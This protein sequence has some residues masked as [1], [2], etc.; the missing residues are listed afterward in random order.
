MQSCTDNIR[1]IYIPQYE[2]RYLPSSLGKDLEETNQEQW[3]ILENKTVALFPVY[4]EEKNSTEFATSLTKETLETLKKQNLFSDI[5]LIS[6]ENI[7][8]DSQILY[9]TYTDAVNAYLFTEKETAKHLANILEVQFF[10]F[11]QIV[12]WP[13]QSCETE[14][15]IHLRMVLIN[16]DSGSVLWIGDNFLGE[17]D[18]YDNDRIKETANELYDKI[19]VSFLEQFSKNK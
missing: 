5:K 16:T 2:Q 13:C 9:E 1:T 10:V 15:R 19:L 12:F 6:S 8:D 14:D 7:P 17:I 4:A 18:K 11:I 3:Q